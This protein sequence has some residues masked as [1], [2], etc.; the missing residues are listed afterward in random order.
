MGYNRTNSQNYTT[1]ALQAKAGNFSWNSKLGIAN[2]PGINFPIVNIGEGIPALGRANAD[3]NVDNGERLNDYVTWVKGNHTLTIG[4]DFRNQLYSTYGLYGT[5]VFTT[6]L[7][8]RP[9]PIQILP[10]QAETD[11]PVSY[12]ALNDANRTVIGHVA[13]WTSQYYAAFVQDD[14]KVSSRLTL[15]LGFR[16]DLDVPRKESKN[17]TSNFSPSAP[18]PEAGNIAGALVFGNNCNNCNPRWADTYYKDFGPRI[19]FAY[20]PMGF[21]DKVVLRGGY[22]I[23]YSP[24]QYTDFGGDQV[25][26][27]SATPDFL[28]SG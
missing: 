22:G 16:W 17:L 2:A 11:L 7:A 18:N 1:G 14:Y 21:G 20:R 15:N 25:Q 26:G 5:V 27:F 12:G 24:L 19:G 9:R 3:D 8:L 23:Y 6:S 13:R 28:Q 10:V 4:F